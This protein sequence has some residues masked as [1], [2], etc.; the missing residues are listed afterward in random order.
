[1]NATITARGHIITQNT[2][3]KPLL[4]ATTFVESGTRDV[5]FCGLNFTSAIYVGDMPDAIMKNG[6]RHFYSI[7][8]LKQ[9]KI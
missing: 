4:L 3:K 2:L 9:I 1:M 8:K 5:T 7:V 6:D